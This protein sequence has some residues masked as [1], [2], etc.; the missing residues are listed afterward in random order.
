MAPVQVQELR[1]TAAEERADD[2]L[3]ETSASASVPDSEGGDADAQR[4]RA[5]G[6]SQAGR[7]F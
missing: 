1:A 5:T 2:D 7:A 3:L 4:A 6:S